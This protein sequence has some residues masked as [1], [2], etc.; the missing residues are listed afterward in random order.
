MYT[1]I[2]YTAVRGETIMN[3]EYVDGDVYYIYKEFL[4][5]IM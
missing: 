1:K 3:F 2:Y 4:H 5:L